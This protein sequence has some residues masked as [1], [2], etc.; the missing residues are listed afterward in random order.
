MWPLGPKRPLSNDELDWQLAALHWLVLEDDGLEPV[1]SGR[2]ACPDDADFAPNGVTGHARAEQLLAAVMAVSGMGEGWPTQLVAQAQARGWIQVN[3]MGTIIPAPD[4]Q[5]AAGTFSMHM[6]DAA[7]APARPVAVITYDPAQLDDEAGLIATLAHEVAHYRLAYRTR[8]WPGGE[9]LHEYLTDLTAVFHGFGIFLANNAR[10]Y[11]A[12]Q[13]G[14]GGHQW[15][16]R[17]AGYLSERALV[18][19]L[20]LCER[21]AGRDPATARRYL[22][23]YLQKDLDI[24]ARYFRDKDVVASVMATDL[25]DYGVDMLSDQ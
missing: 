16:F 10:D 3:S 18:T 9:D 22:K 2:L 1:Q 5:S 4:E 25:A 8:S 23:P 24:A 20:V 15:Q 21:L 14:G 19:A 7:V 6:P 13:L 11:H 17:A 12:E